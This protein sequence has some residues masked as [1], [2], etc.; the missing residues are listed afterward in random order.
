MGLG[1]SNAIV[2][3]PRASRTRRSNAVC[4]ART[5]ASGDIL[6]AKGAI[7]GRRVALVRGP[8]LGRRARR[9]PPPSALD[10]FARAGQ[11]AT[12][13]RR[14]APASRGTRPVQLAGDCPRAAGRALPERRRPPRFAVSRAMTRSMCAGSV[15]RSWCAGRSVSTAVAR[16]ARPRGA[17]RRTAR[18]CRLRRSRSAPDA[19]SGPWR[20]SARSSD[21][22]RGTRPPAARPSPPSRRPARRPDRRSGSDGLRFCDRDRSRAHGSTGGIDQRA[23]W[24]R[25]HISR[26][27][28]RVRLATTC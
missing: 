8:R 17:S 12:P 21:R 27:P 10:R 23:V 6:A 24:W 15:S 14:L 13:A 19:A 9:S 20:S 18:G 28:S 3:R 25:S 2:G 4:T 7:L 22:C 5:R 26:R 11:R 16:H 1:Q